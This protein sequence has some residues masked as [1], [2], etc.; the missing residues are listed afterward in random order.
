MVGDKTKEAL[1]KLLELENGN[2]WIDQVTLQAGIGR[3]KRVLEKEM[4]VLRLEYRQ[5]IMD[6]VDK[7]TRKGLD[8]Y[9]QV[10]NE[11]EELNDLEMLEYFAEELTDALVY[12][13]DLKVKIK[14]L[15][16]IGGDEE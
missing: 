8:K 6:R 16:E 4:E 11:N 9:G 13:E 7:Q 10:L 3:V 12:I 5:S 14:K 1:S 2:G 15:K